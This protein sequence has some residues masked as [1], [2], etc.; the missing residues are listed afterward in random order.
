MTSP[1]APMNIITGVGSYL[2]K[3]IVTNKE[4]E[5]TLDTTDEWIRERTGISQRH[6]AADGEYTSDLALQACIGALDN[7]GR[8]PQDIDLIIVATS[9]PDRVL[10]ATANILHGKLGATNNAASFDINVACSGFVYAMSVADSLIKNGIATKALVVGAET[11]SRIVD[12]QD[13]GTCILFGDGAGAVVLEKNPAGDGRGILGSSMFSNGGLAH[14]IDT[15]GGIS[16]AGRQNSIRMIGKEVYRHATE[17]MSHGISSLMQ[18]LN[19]NAT[20]IDWLVPHQANE[21]IIDSVI[22]KTGINPAK[23]VKTMSL[24]ANTSAAS[25]PLA[26]DFLHIQKKLIKGNIVALQALGSGITWASMIIKW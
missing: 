24:H 16:K 8:K 21:R 26:L 22:T 5:A 25:I 17:K 3:R 20:D 23:V 1:A 9:T 11:Y 13:R 19:L 2:P 18:Q 15:E 7:A 12:W 6:I 14:L 10:P 4:L